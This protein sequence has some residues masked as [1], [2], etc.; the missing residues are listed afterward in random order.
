MSPP[1]VGL[2]PLSAPNPGVYS[3]AFTHNGKLLAVGDGNGHTYLWDVAT[4]KLIFPP[5]TDPGPQGVNSVAFSPD[6][7]LLAVGDGNGPTYLW[8]V[9]TRKLIFPP[10]PTLAPRA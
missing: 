9:A 1:A 7:K 8:D 4:R 2:P 10:S 5:F 6:D 3:V